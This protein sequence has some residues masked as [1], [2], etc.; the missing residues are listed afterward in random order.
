VSEGL[1]LGMPRAG[2]ST[3]YICDIA[4]YTASFF[5]NLSGLV[6]DAKTLK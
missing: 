3:V 1:R 2:A 5:Y 4:R 6:V